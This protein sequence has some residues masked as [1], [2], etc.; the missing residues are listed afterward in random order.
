[1]D[2]KRELLRHTVATL[3]Y[4]G[5]KAVRG[6]PAGF[7]G[8]RAGEKTRTPGEIL[9]HIGDLLDW[10]LG[11]AKGKYEWHDSP[12]LAWNQEVARFFAALEAFD[13]CLA[14]ELPLGSA[15]EKL[16]QGPIAD[17]LTH[18]GQIAMLRRLV[19]APVRGENYFR[20]E[21]VAGRVGDEQAAPAREFE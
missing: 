12:P 16:F 13:A 10:A 5:G 15:A 20:A 11:L 6:A 17:A 3:A 2:A 9:A 1:M 8:F 18:V 21:I 14:S 7:A 4:R 19:G